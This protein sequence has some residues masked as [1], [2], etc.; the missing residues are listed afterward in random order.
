MRFNGILRSGRS[1]ALD[2]WIDDALDTEFTT[3]RRF[4]SAF[5]AGILMP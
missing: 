3:I 4:A 5:C 2:E 1:E